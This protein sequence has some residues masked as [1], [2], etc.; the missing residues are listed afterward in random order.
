MSKYQTHS[1]DAKLTANKN[2]L[3]DYKK[4]ALKVGFRTVYKTRDAHQIIKQ[5]SKSNSI[6]IP[7]NLT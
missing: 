5:T 3:R 6:T 2:K 7:K 4:T 1:P